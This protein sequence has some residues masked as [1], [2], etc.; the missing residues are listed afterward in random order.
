MICPYGHSACGL[1]VV[2][3]SVGVARVSLGW[4][5]R[6]WGW[7]GRVRYRQGEN[8]GEDYPYRPTTALTVS[9]EQ[10]WIL[11]DRVGSLETL[12]IL[13][14]VYIQYGRIIPLVCK[15]AVQFL[16]LFYYLGTYEYL[17]YTTT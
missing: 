10:Y 5:S 1:C 8:P 11:L 3:S 14:S 17:V 2:N 15:L 7:Q 4:E 13:A 12:S 9:A 6:D 16:N